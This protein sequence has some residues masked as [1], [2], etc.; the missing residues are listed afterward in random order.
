[1]LDRNMLI[2]VRRENGD[3]REAR[4]AKTADIQ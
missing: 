3:E 1:M 4:N 2:L